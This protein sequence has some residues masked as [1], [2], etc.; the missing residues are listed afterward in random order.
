LNVVATKVSPRLLVLIQFDPFRTHKAVEALR[1]A[2]GLGSHNEG[3]DLK[4]I[5]SGRAPHLLAEDS[6]TIMDADILEKHL[7]VFVEWGTI[8]AIAPGSDSPSAWAPDVVIQPLTEAD[9]AVLLESA[10]R[11]LV[12]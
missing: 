11:V 7:P 4:I 8:F 1:I 3:Q 9:M 2:L 6:S 10:D 12:F 5:L